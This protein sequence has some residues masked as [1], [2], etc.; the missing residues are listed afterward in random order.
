MERR[1]CIHTSHVDETIAL[2]AEIGARLKRGDIVAMYG[3]IGSG[4]THFVKGIAHG[5]G[6]ASQD[7]IT[8]PSYIYVREYATDP[9]FAHVDLYHLEGKNL[10][11]IG[12]ADYLDYDGV[13]VIEW[14]ERLRETLP[15]HIRVRFTIVD[16][17]KRIIRIEDMIGRL[18]GFKPKSADAG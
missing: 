7:R 16:E 5:L 12:L 18:N 11:D 2:G 8:S 9:P 17:S 13:T 10:D 6:V 15:P 14:A 3:E 1:L 4:K